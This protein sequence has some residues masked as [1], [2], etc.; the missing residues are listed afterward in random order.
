MAGPSGA[1]FIA[2]SLLELQD[3]PIDVCN[4]YHGELGGFGIFT[5]Q[6]VPLK[7]YQALRAFQ[8]LVETPRRVETRG[9]VPGKLAFAAGLSADGRA[10]SFLVSNFA[11]PRSEILLNWKGFSWTGGVIAEIRTVDV[12][13]DFSN[14]RNESVAGENASLRLD[15]KAPALRS[16]GCAPQAEPRQNGPC[17]SQHPPT[18]LFSSAARLGTRRFLWQEAAP[19]QAQRWRRGLST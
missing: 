16:S 17:R 12:E 15:L 1:S 7:A 11:D 19:G 3:A 14:A 2:A 10:A 13:N 5:E 18:A 6:G 8:G 9:A 4:F